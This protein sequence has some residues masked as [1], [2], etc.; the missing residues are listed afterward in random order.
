MADTESQIPPWI[1]STASL[2]LRHPKSQLLALLLLTLSV[3]SGMAFLELDPS[4]ERIFPK[5]HPAVTNFQEFRQ[6]FGN[7][8]FLLVAYSSKKPI[9]SKDELIRLQALTQKLQNITV[10]IGETEKHTVKPIRAARS[11][12]TTPNVTMDLSTFPPKP[13]ISPLYPQNLK[14]LSEADLNKANESILASPFVKPL[15]LSQDGLSTSI[16]LE[17]E[18]PKNVSVRDAAETVLELVNA[19]RKIVQEDI[20][21]NGLEGHVAGSPVVKVDIVQ[22]IEKELLIFTLPLVLIAAVVAFLIFRNIR[23]VLLPMAVILLTSLLVYGIMGYLGLAVHPM[24][25]LLSPLMFVVGI[26]DSIHVIVEIENGLADR[27]PNQSLYDTLLKSTALVLPP[28]FLTSLTTTIGFGSLV[29][30]DISPVAEF[31]FLAALGTS[32]AFFVTFLLIPPIWLL[33]P[34]HKAAEGKKKEAPRLDKLASFVMKTTKIFA[35]VSLLFGAYCVSK[36]PD[37]SFNTD[38][39]GFFDEDTNIQKGVKYIQSR[40]AGIGAMEIVVKK[41]ASSPSDKPL[42]DPQILKSM[43]AFEKDLL[44]NIPEVDAAFSAADFLVFAKKRMNKI[45]GR[46]PTEEPPTAKE[47]LLM[48]RIFAS[49]KSDQDEIRRFINVTETRARISVRVE[50]MGSERMTQILEEVRILADKHFDKDT[51][52]TVT[53]T[54][55]IFSETAYFM[56]EGQMRSFFWALI[57]ITVVMIISLRSLRLGLISLAPNLFPIAVMFGA[58]AMLE[59]PMNSFNS[60]VAS[61]A[62]GIAV[63]DTIHMLI[64]YKRFRAIQPMEA[65]LRETIAHTGAAIVSTSLLLACGFGVLLLGEFKPTGHFGLLTCIAIIS[66]VLGDLFLLPALIILDEKIFGA[67]VLNKLNKTNEEKAEQ[68]P[69]N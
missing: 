63:D 38:F 27:K 40:F 1:R 61:V 13:K 69:T 48:E 36:F 25:T 5:N 29:I 59:I 52:V 56:M 43:L 3:G 11:L 53:G 31:G 66:A 54:P 8:E 50:T 19:A 55:V 14:E 20:T 65:A 16:I 4:T 10:Q 17:I 30:S 39:V 67:C 46:P 24:T 34:D 60:M 15:L 41:E 62:I 26:A 12:T 58:M 37:I 68:T 44:L 47:I 64:G 28:C 49:M 6:V 32:F 33:L 57:T 35:V 22:T 42:R 7:D 9:L 23:G 21:N 2:L 51:S 18:R 45:S